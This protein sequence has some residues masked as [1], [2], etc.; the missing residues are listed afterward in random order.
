MNNKLKLL[1]PQKG[2]KRTFLVLLSL[3][4]TFLFPQHSWAYFSNQETIF[5]V[6][7]NNSPVLQYS[8]N[9]KQASELAIIQN[10]SLISI[11]Y[12]VAPAKS[13]PACAAIRLAKTSNSQTCP[14]LNK[15]TVIATAYSSSVD[16]TDSNPFITASGAHVRD[17]IIAANF[18]KIGTK[19]KIP[20]LYGDKIFVVEDR[21][22]PKNSH[23][24]DIW[25]SSKS[26]ALQFGVKKAE[27]VVL[28]N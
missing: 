9:D 15:R 3:A 6:T 10:N 12:P 18:L 11:N 25:M 24:I 19:V 13:G 16:E 2:K 23:K 26:Q 17:G 14:V 4:F 27:I 8:T 1:L 28:E 21:M 22:A 5:I 7:Y 20:N